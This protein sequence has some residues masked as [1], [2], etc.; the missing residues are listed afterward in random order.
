MLQRNFLFGLK[1]FE[2]HLNGERNADGIPRLFSLPLAKNIPQNLIHL[3]LLLRY[4]TNI[5]FL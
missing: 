3:E 5:I 1:I 4:Y 2:Q